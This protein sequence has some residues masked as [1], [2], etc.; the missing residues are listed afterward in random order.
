[1]AAINRDLEWLSRQA[2]EYCSSTDDAIGV[3]E[4]LDELGKLGWGFSTMDDLEEID[5]SARL[6]VNQKQ[7]I[8]ELLKVYTWYFAWDYTEMPGLRRELVEHRLPI[9]AS[10][11][12]YKQ[13]ARNFKPEIVGRVKEEVDRL[14]QDGF[15]QPCRYADWVSNIVPVEMKN[16]GKIWICVYFRNLKRATPKDEYSMPIADLLID[17]ASGNKVISLLDGNMGYN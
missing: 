17:S 8:I 9:K 6:D 1:M 3:V 11:R 12:P 4:D 15:I 14:L 2:A 5:I 7:E 13:G 10:F 16:T